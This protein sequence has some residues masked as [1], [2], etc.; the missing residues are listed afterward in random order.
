MTDE[1]GQSGSS[2]FY[3][4]IFSIASDNRIALFIATAGIVFIVSSLFFL[5]KKDTGGEVVFTENSASDSGEI[6]I[7]V[8]IEGSVMNPGVYTLESGARVGDL[9]IMAG[10]YTEGADREWTAKYLNQAAKLT[11]GGKIYIPQ[12]GEEIAKT[13][14]LGTADSVSTGEKINI[15]TATLTELDKLPGVGQV[16]AGKIISGRPYLTAEE[17]NTKK[18]VGNAVWEKIREL[19]VVY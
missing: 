1:T 5:F 6:K 3:K 13:S 7:V 4:Q 14:L 15:N 2:S 16:T 10:G 8:D 11:D 18:I 17:L 12:A 9:L 19:V